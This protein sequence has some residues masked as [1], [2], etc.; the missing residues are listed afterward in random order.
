LIPFHILNRHYKEA[1]F[2]SLGISFGFLAGLSYSMFIQNDYFWLSYLKLPLLIFV[3]SSIC[4]IIVNIIRDRFDR[5]QAKKILT[6]LFVVF[7]CIVVLVILI[8]GTHLLSDR[9][10]NP[11]QFFSQIK[12]T[13]RTIFS[14]N[15]DYVLGING[16]VVAMSYIGILF[17][18]LSKDLFKKGF[19]FFVLLA[20][21]SF[22]VILIGPYFGL[23]PNLNTPRAM[24]Y[25]SISVPVFV[26]YCVY[27]FQKSMH[28]KFL[29]ILLF[30]VV[31]VTSAKYSLSIARSYT[32]YVAPKEVI[33]YLDDH[34]DGRSKIYSDTMLLA[35]IYL[36]TNEF[37]S[38]ID[39]P[40]NAMIEDVLVNPKNYSVQF[41]VITPQMNSSSFSLHN[42]KYQKVFES[43]GYL[44]YSP[45]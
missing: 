11:N 29:S 37:N 19:M 13:Y 3:F 35:S 38:I 18:F 33:Q 12:S 41:V 36:P 17:L 27:F 39:T 14:A 32:S 15:D 8:L 7:V 6:A 16:L 5:T 31:V 43:K 22:I 21:V 10:W 40:K 26:S 9:F 30:S 25:F 1:F 44:I 4:A 45:K 24:F 28:N 34:Y 42:E 20:G 23:D 2:I